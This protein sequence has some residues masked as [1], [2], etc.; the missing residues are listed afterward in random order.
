MLCGPEISNQATTKI[1]PDKRG[2][3]YKE[4][5]EIVDTRYN[6]QNPLSRSGS[7]NKLHIER[8]NSPEPDNE[9]T[10]WEM[11]ALKEDEADYRHCQFQH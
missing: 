11:S 4:Y 3:G 1:V 2:F 10:V 9:N 8:L 7:I 6:I 5:R